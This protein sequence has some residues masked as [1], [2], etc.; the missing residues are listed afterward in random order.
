M[1]LQDQASTHPQV[2][3]ALP[4]VD[5]ASAPGVAK[6]KTKAKTTGPLA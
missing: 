2:V 5:E 1:R 4:A 6:E 3:E